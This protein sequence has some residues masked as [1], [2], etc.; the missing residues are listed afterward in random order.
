MS[1]GHRL[2]AII[3]IWQV[4]GLIVAGCAAAAAVASWA[5]ARTPPPE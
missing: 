4:V 2:T 5:I 3:V 1:S